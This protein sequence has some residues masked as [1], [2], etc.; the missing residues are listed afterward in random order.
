M[1]TASSV[2]LDLVETQ[3]QVSSEY[4]MDKAMV[5][6]AKMDGELSHYVK[7]VQSTINHVKEEHPEKHTRFNITGGEET[8]GF[9]G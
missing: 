3:T 1:D 6:F 5:E 7:V 9:T 4:S 8:F 2:A